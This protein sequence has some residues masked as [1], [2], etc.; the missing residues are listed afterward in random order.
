MKN[1]WDLKYIEKKECIEATISEST[2]VNS[3]SNDVYVGRDI[4]IKCKENINNQKSLNEINFLSSNNLKHEVIDD[5]LVLSKIEARNIVNN[6]IN[7][8]QI[9]LNIIESI[10]QFRKMNNSN[11]GK[12]DLLDKLKKS[13][14][15]ILSILSKLKIDND[16]YNNALYLASIEDE[17][18]L[19]HSDLNDNNILTNETNIY[20]IDF[21][22]VAMGNKYH[23][24]TSF[25][26]NW[27]INRESIEYICSLANINIK[28]T[29][30]LSIIWSVRYYNWNRQQYSRTNSQKYKDKMEFFESRIKYLN[31]IK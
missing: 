10:S 27:D 28:N 15:E 2:P 13:E 5:Y 24:I 31:E 25:I 12:Y 3:L 11:I 7:D 4:V 22:E 18:I 6:E 17:N 21:E 9:L 23:D 8:K 20:L 30:S 14:D 1:F 19:C 16:Y 26:S 29:I